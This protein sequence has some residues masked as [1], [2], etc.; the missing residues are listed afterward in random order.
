VRASPFPPDRVR[1]RTADSS[2]WAQLKVTGGG[3]IRQLNCYDF[4]NYDL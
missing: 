3:S 4:S 1:G 2:L